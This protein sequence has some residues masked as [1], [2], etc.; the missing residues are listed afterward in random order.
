LEDDVRRYIMPNQEVVDYPI[1]EKTILAIK[2]WAV[3]QLRKSKERKQLRL[4]KEIGL[5]RL[6]PILVYR[7]EYGDEIRDGCHR[8]YIAWKLGLK[9]IKA[10][11]KIR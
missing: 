11:V 9:T 2:I 1:D 10:E 7:F 8:L 5:I 6:P 3:R 4:L